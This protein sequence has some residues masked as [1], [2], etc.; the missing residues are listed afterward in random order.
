MTQ[1]AAVRGALIG[2][3]LLPLPRALAAQSGTAAP[4]QGEPSVHLLGA[5]AITS[6]LLADGNGTRVRLAPAPVVGARVLLGSWRGGAVRPMLTL[7]AG[8]SGVRLRAGDAHW[9]AGHALQTELFA[10]AAWRVHPRAA[11]HAAVGAIW[12]LGPHDVAP[13]RGNRAPRPAA[14]AGFTLRWSAR[15]RT[16]LEAGAQAFRLTPEPGRAGGVLRVL[17]GVSHAL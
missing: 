6:P 12:L 4:L 5:V 10:G 14:D 9:S 8:A 15:S 1:C 7:R 13:F 3:T 16:S 11:V 17:L 2:L